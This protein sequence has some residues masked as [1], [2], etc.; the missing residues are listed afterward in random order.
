MRRLGVSEKAIRQ[1]Q[2]HIRRRKRPK[3]W[4]P[5]S[6]ART[7]VSILQNIQ[8][9]RLEQSNRRS[10]LLQHSAFSTSIS[11]PSFLEIYHEL[12]RSCVDLNE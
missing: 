12:H 3:R 1:A 11:F 4:R 2:E 6:S 8:K 7:P 5:R 10:T 9:R